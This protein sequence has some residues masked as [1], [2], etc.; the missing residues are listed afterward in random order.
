VVREDT[1]GRFIMLVIKQI[2]QR[3]RHTVVLPQVLVLHSV[4]RGYLSPES[5]LFCVELTIYRIQD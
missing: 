4:C 1:Y 2:M 5:Q 3:R